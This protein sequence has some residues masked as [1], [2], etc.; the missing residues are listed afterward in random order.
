MAAGI[1]LRS[2]VFLDSLQPQYAAF[3]GTTAQGFLPLAG[4][5]VLFVEVAPGIEINRLTDVALKATTVKPGMQIIERVF[6]LLEVHSP[7][8]SETRAA[9]AA[10]LDSLAVTETDR[11]KPEVLSSQL[12]RR[13]DDH[14]AQLINRMRHGQMIIPGQTLYVLECAP[15]AYA[16]FAANEAEKAANINVLEVRAFGAVGRVYLG[17]EEQDMEVGW[18]AAVDALEGLEGRTNT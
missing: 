5:A 14:H 4:E 11:L 9:G 12:I 6:G 1:E 15:A 10:I 3:L 7:E 2:Y 17:G 13:I 16:A 8:Q 18:R